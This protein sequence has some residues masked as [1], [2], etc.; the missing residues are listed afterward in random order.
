[1]EFKK[2]VRHPKMEN[3]GKGTPYLWVIFFKI[4]G[5]CVNITP[6]FRL[7][8]KGTFEFKP[9]SHGNLGL[10]DLT[11]QKNISIPNKI[12]K[13][14]TKI[15]PFNIPYFEQKAPGMTGAIVVMMEENNVSYK[16][17]EAGHKALNEKVTSAVNQ[18]LKEFDP[19]LVDVNNVMPSIKQFFEDKVAETT[20]SMQNDIVKAIRSSQKLLRNLWTYFN[21]DSLIGFHVWN[22]NQKELMESPKQSIDFSHS[23]TTNEFNDWEIFGNICIIDEKTPRK[24]VQKKAKSI[25]APTAQSIEIEKGRLTME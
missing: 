15:E 2:L 22:Y 6:A 20:D 14:Q 3:R 19:R 1:M 8:G 5:T 12:G 23:W 10:T 18:A 24:A 13:W 11:T 7:K 21:P 16:G 9:G 17:A 25:H 4:D